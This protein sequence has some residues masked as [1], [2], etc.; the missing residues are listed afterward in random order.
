MITNAIK[1]SPITYKKQVRSQSP[2]S[3]TSEKINTNKMNYTSIYKSSNLTFGWCTPHIAAMQSLNT[4]FNSV[5]QKT[6]EKQNEA[7]STYEALNR[8]KQTQ[9]ALM[10]KANTDAAKLFSQ[11]CN[12]QYTAA[13]M[14][15]SYAL[16]L[17]KPLNEMMQNLD[18][19][20]NPINTLITIN[21]VTK[22]K[23]APGIDKHT[24]KEYTKEETHKA[25]SGTQLYTTVML[26][27]KLHEN[28]NSPAL[29]DESR[30]KINNLTAIIHTTI[31]NIYG[32]NTFK[33]IKELSSIGAEPTLE[34]KK[35]S[36]DL[37]KE[38]DLK[39]QELVL[40]EEFETGLLDL[41][42]HQ[43]GIEGKTIANQNDGKIDEI[44]LKVAYHTH[45]KI[46]PA[47]RKSLIQNPNQPQHNH[48][49]M[50]EE[51]HIRFHEEEANRIKEQNKGE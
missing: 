4:M 36:I 31:D 5:I 32:E 33:R 23:M 28:S 37:I 14:L 1:Y 34:Q 39:A 15:P 16:S 21:N 43:N 9:Y 13:E 42:N 3:N 18:A 50:S 10:D 35:A 47:E 46:M 45:P 22:L 8:H 44:S 12:T 11:Y 17:N 51:E 26:L 27:D 40:P 7:R 20:N 49:N 6:L 30:T 38:L 2:Q 25:K 41:I 29:T 48:G 24:G 19:I